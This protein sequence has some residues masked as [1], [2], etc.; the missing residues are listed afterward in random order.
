[1]LLL[2]AGVL[3]LVLVALIIACILIG[4]ATKE[5]MQIRGY[6]NSTKLNSAVSWYNWCITALWL[7][8]VIATFILVVFAIQNSRSEIHRH[9]FGSHGFVKISMWIMLAVIVA[10]GIFLFT[11]YNDMKSATAYTMRK[12]ATDTINSYLVTSIIIIGAIALVLLG[13]VISS[14][15]KKPKLHDNEIL[16][17]A[18]QQKEQI[19]E[20]NQPLEIYPSEN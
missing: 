11:G 14:L 9:N 19:E 6:S 10:A 4:L 3:L 15:F 7:A 18:E 16:Y 12:N 2:E 20:H 8:A 1:M 13:L 5:L 17:L